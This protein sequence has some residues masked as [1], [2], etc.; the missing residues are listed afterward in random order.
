[1]SMTLKADGRLADRA[2]AAL[3]RLWRR[4][5]S[6]TGRGRFQLLREIMRFVAEILVGLLVLPALVAAHHSTAEYDR[7]AVHELEGELVGVRWRNP[8]V[9]FTVRVNRPDGEVEDWELASAAV[10]VPCAVPH[11]PR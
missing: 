7:S 8:H 10:Y 4:S 5:Y 2:P 1:M 3:N 9:M 6:D 11:T